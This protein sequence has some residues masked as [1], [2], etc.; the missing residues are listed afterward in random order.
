MAQVIIG[1]ASGSK[2]SSMARQGIPSE[3]EQTSRWLTNHGQWP[4]YKMGRLQTDHG[5]DCFWTAG[6]M[7]YNRQLAITTIIHHPVKTTIW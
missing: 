4:T 3:S 2:H 1:K 6:H 5:P 7:I